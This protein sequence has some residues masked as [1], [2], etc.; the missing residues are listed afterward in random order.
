MSKKTGKGTRGRHGRGRRASA[1]ASRPPRP[2]TRVP[3][4]PSQWRAFA[5]VFGIALAARLLVVAQL[6]D[7]P[8]VR[9]PRL[10]SLEYL[11]WAR[12]IAFGTAGWPAY[13]A[14]APGYS[15]FLAA[16]LRSSGDSLHAVRLAQS[17][18]GALTCALV[19]ALATRWFSLPAGIA[20]G[21]LVAVYGPLVLVDS[22]ILA[23]GL[24]VF[25]LVL[26]LWVVSRRSSMDAAL[27]GGVVLGLAALVRPT[28]LAALPAVAAPFLAS[29]T[30]A[31]RKWARIGLLT[32]ACAVTVA[33][34][35]L[36]NWRTTGSPMLQGYGGMNFYLGNAPSGDGLPRARLG[37]GWD[38]LDREAARAG[39]AKPADQDRYYLGK[40]LREI[41][42][43]PVKYAALVGS[44]LT[45]LLQADEVRDSHSYYFFTAQ[46]AFL[47]YLPAYGVLLSLAACGLAWSVVRRRLPWLPVLYLLGM[48]GTCLLLV[49]GSRYRMP[50]VP[51]LAV[52]AGYG[53]ASCAADLSQMRRGA[54]EGYP[55]AV[56]RLLWCAVLTLVVFAFA[57]LRSHAPSH[58][59]AEEWAFTGAALT[60][61]RKVADAEEA[62]R[63]ALAADPRSG[64]AWDGLGLL[65]FDQ[66]RLGEAQQALLKALSADP[67]NSQAHAHLGL[68]HE[69]AGSPR[70]AIEEFRRALSISPGNQLMTKALARV[71]L[72]TGV[73]AE[74]GPLYRQL[75]AADPDDASSHL[76]LAWVEGSQGHA[77]AGASHAAKAAQL[78][79]AN[80]QAWL[81]LSRLAAEAGDF[82]QADSAVDRARQLLGT[83][84]LEVTLASVLIMTAKGRY[85]DADRELRAVLSKYPT[86]DVAAD[87]FLENA[88][89][90]GS[91]AE[92]ERFL[93]TVQ[94]TIKR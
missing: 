51:V 36:Q 76:G 42:D 1:G 75:V 57:H 45:W 37:G 85:N 33:P 53:V 21:L 35:V 31:P 19:A 25:L 4:V 9:T 94:A 58:N 12:E 91:R 60:S 79:P 63:R 38:A 52:F 15:F 56:R 69:R 14:H 68:V 32:A 59:L 27:A 84:S 86:L 26:A 73:T 88:G 46:S 20:A 62:Y 28:G 54:A 23:E 8:I 70:E 82:A 50:L 71:L 40:G 5:I 43:A 18:L 24:L 6:S 93:A 77:A 49:V 34:A 2:A 29:H 65:Y 61:E 22:S 41:R 3:R 7:L 39:Y 90:R 30:S 80:P 16:V 13:P 89:R 44:K 48:A 11:Q 74:A 81:L 72:S 78:E 64:F 92:A 10:D 55:N 66:G 47:R 67:E 17:V 83:D 87:L